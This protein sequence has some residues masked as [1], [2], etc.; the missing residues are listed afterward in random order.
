MYSF[1][2]IGIAGLNRDFVDKDL[3]AIGARTFFPD[4]D[5]DDYF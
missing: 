4:V 2:T 3:D 1:D 5:E